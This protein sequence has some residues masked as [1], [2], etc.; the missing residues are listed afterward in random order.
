MHSTNHPWR[1][2]HVIHKVE[3]I[4][5]CLISSQEKDTIMAV[6]YTCTL[7]RGCVQSAP[8][9]YIYVQ[10]VHGY[11]L[12]E[13]QKTKLENK[14]I[15][16]GQIIII[17][18]CSKNITPTMAAQLSTEQSSIQNVNIRDLAAADQINKSIN[19]TVFSPKQAAISWYRYRLVLLIFCSYVYL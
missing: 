17:T 6:G 18:Q 10:I 19:V 16:M 9:M 15:N 8:H 13:L 7:S 2:V 3:A 14:F 1:H 11:K 4:G 5:E 12:I